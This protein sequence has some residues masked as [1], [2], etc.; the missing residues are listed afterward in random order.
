VV[1]PIKA[2]WW[3]L[4]F[5]GMVSYYA[6][7]IGCSALVMQALAPLGNGGA[8][9]VIGAGPG[10]NVSS[11]LQ[12]VQSEFKI[13]VQTFYCKC[14]VSYVGHCFRHSSHPISKLFSLPF[15]GRLASLRLERRRAPSESAQMAREVLRNLGMRVTALIAGRPDVRGQS[16]YVFR[17]GE[18][19]FEEFRDGGPGWTF[20]KEDS[21]A[22]DLR[23]NLLLD[24]YRRRR[25]SGLPALMNL[26][27]D[28]ISDVQGEAPI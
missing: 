22:V 12:Q 16:G 15:A 11:V 13:C 28:S 5:R 25:G 8:R 9:K 3:Q 27:Q 6:A 18:G 26:L 7:F 14:V 19:W 17:W 20:E 4:Q 1:A 2:K 23:V 24:I 10:F 21:S